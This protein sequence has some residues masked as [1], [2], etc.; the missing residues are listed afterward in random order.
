MSDAQQAPRGKQK[1][2][3]PRT[4]ECSRSRQCALPIYLS[5][6]GAPLHSFHLLQSC[7][8]AS[9]RAASQ[10]CRSPLALCCCEPLSQELISATYTAYS[11][12]DS[13]VAAHSTSPSTKSL[14]CMHFITMQ[15][16]CRDVRRPSSWKE[17]QVTRSKVW[18][19]ILRGIVFLLFL[20][21]ICYTTATFDVDYSWAVV[22]LCNMVIPVSCPV[23]MKH[24]D[25]IL[26]PFILQN[27]TIALR[28][29]TCQQSELRK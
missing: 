12:Q 10:T 27:P 23:V 29:L 3:F 7:S 4:I 13:A 11:Q 21:H 22:L 19:C 15:L 17:P 5:N 8:H 24:A 1:L 25:G 9:A 28:S 26:L 20:W 16:M 18:Y 2:Q 14:L 6:T